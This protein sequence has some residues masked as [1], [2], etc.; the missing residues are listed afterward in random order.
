LK[1]SGLKTF[2]QG[3]F[4]TDELL[5]SLNK[6]VWG[7]KRYI[8]LKRVGVAGLEKDEKADM[9]EFTVGGRREKTRDV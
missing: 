4:Q 9:R 3:S 1:I 2:G 8:W 5:Q 7:E 6:L